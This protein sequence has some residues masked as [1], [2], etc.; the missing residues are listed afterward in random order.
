[1]KMIDFAERLRD[2]EYVRSQHRHQKAGRLDEIPAGGIGLVI[3]RRAPRRRAEQLLPPAA[4]MKLIRVLH[5]VPRFMAENVIDTLPPSAAFHV[6]DFLLLQ[7]IRRGWA[8]KN[9]NAMP[10]VLSGLNHSLEIQAWGRTRRSR[11]FNSSCSALRQ[12]SSQVPS[13]LTLRSRRRSWSNCSSGR[14]AQ[15]NFL[16]AM[17]SRTL[18]GT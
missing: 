17:K 15:A 10:G 2:Q 3:S 6:E 16:V 18:R 5:H 13:T 9:G 11:S 4:P 8:K 1:M 12:S 14:E 7:R